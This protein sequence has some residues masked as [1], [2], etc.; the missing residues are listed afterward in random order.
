VKSGAT[1]LLITGVSVFGLWTGAA[2]AADVALIVGT[3]GED[4][5]TEQSD[6]IAS[7]ADLLTSRGYEVYD[8]QHAT[9]ADIAAVLAQVAN[10]LPETERLILFYAGDTRAR[11]A[12]AWLLPWDFQGEGRIDAIF[13]GVALDALLDMAATL[14]GRSAVVIG[15]D[16]AADDAAPAD[17]AYGDLT[18]GIGQP[19]VPQG[20]LLIAGPVDEAI[21]AV[22]EG[23]LNG[24]RSVAEALE[25][26]RTGVEVFGFL[27]PE[28]SFIAQTTAYETGAD[29]R[30]TRP[31][32][33][34][35]ESSPEPAPAIDPAEAA[36]VK[37]AFDQ[38]TRRGIQER[39]TVLGYDTRGIDG[40]FG[41]GTRSAIKEWQKNQQFPGTGFLTANQMRLLTALG[42]ARSAQL[43]AAAERARQ[44]EEAADATFW[45]T[46]GANGRGSGLRNYLERY[47]DGNHSAQARAD[48]EKLDKAA[49]AKARHED[50][51]A[52]EAA[53]K[54]HSVAAYQRYLNDY[55]KGAF[56]D[57]AQA[58]IAD[59]TA[60]PDRDRAKA[61]AKAAEEAMGL[62]KGSRALIE[63]QL[64]MM[65]Y[66]V[67]EQDGKFDAKT[68]RALRE[69]QT[70]QGLEVTGYVSQPT[71]QALIIA[72][73]GLR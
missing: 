62:G 38:T 8:R 73:L 42:E 33:E 12:R 20:V 51:A 71:V 7:M 49:R 28:A 14:P 54:R 16:G 26:P 53:E 40:V 55:P 17:G 52:W 37:L 21:S 56:A 5:A 66:D 25:T 11:G 48:L 6:Q 72:S 64:A 46:T 61:A 65:G 68:R 60:K 47:P 3:G 29:A 36:E 63:G 10:R 27:S 19:A 15:T 13:G 18:T 50:R 31:D 59:L 4:N 9:R 1:A 67:G 34:A 43:S 30:A 57:Q 32:S 44:E 41:P 70:R 23:L 58:R 45:R 22:T 2:K 69:F 39:L 24:S 35:V